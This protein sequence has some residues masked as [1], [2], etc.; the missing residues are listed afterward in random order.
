MSVLT[1]NDSNVHED[2]ALSLTSILVNVTQSLVNKTLQKQKNYWANGLEFDS[3]D[4]IKYYYSI[5]KI[6]KL[7]KIKIKIMIKTFLIYI[8]KK[9]SQ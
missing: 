6:I 8:P 9:S 1:S 4:F 7:S 3:S 2:I 5:K